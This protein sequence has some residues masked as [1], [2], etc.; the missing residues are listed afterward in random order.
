[1][2]C[3]R[4]AETKSGAATASCV[5]ATLDA[6]RL[7]LPVYVESLAQVSTML[8]TEFGQRRL[9]ADEALSKVHAVLGINPAEENPDR[10]WITG[11]A[12][13]SWCAGRPSLSLKA[14]PFPHRH[15]PLTLWRTLVPQLPAY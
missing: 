1:M 5:A 7:T 15:K 6:R 2:N 11:A 3:S 9:E 10:L 12:K 8:T 14:N 13:A 4:A